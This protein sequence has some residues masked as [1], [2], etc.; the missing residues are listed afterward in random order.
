MQ[1]VR[2]EG[3]PGPPEDRHDRSVVTPVR[4]VAW[5]GPIVMLRDVAA[6]EK[7]IPEW[8][9]RGLERVVY[10]GEQR[11]GFIDRAARPIWDAWVSDMESKG[12]PGRELLDFILSES[13][14]HQKAR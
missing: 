6:D 8:D 10:S 4:L 2:S 13:G 3:S 14:K 1:R 11:Q 5:T 7:Y 12:Y 9:R